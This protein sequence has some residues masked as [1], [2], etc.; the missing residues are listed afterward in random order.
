M[1]REVIVKYIFIRKQNVILH[2]KLKE[3]QM[4]TTA[5]ALIAWIENLS[6]QFF[7]FTCPHKESER[8][9]SN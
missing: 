3:N 5:S 1:V 8:E 9:N 2:P 4:E 6:L 7:F